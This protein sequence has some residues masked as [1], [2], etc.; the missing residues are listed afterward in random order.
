MV[1]TQALARATQS[2][3]MFDPAQVDLLTRTICRGATRDELDLF[4]A[5]CRRTGL[6]PFA[7]QVFAVKRWDSRERREVMSIQVSIDGF[8]L[9]AARTGDYAGQVGPLWCGPDSQWRDVW[10][11]KEPPAAAKV[12]VVRRGFVEPLYAVARWDSYAQRNK[13]GN[14]TGMWAKMPD[15]MLGK[16]AEALALRRAFPA[17]LSG[18]YSSDEMA[19]AVTV[20]VEQSAQHAAIEASMHAAIERAQ[21]VEVPANRSHVQNYAGQSFAERTGADPSLEQPVE[22]VKPEP[23][24]PAPPETDDLD[25]EFERLESAQ[26]PASRKFGQAHSLWKACLNKGLCNASHE[27]SPDWDDE[28]VN[29]FIT[30]WTPELTKANRK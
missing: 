17:E 4:L 6:D 9:I 22:R 14:L 11:E 23:P 1:E 3:E 15:L 5:V 16:V 26:K 12:G 13:E 24:K 30:N 7:R 20:E 29:I 28:M 27:P 19:Q 8:R 18:L 2:V 25:G 10:L 21:A